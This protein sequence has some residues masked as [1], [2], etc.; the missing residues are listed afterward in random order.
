MPEDLIAQFNLTM[1][2]ILEK[3]DLVLASD[4]EEKVFLKNLNDLF[5]AVPTL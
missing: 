4:A 5:T 3:A 1:F 2:R